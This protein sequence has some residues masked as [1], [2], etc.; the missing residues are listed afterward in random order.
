MME[1]ADASVLL[2]G[3]SARV[4]PVGA[5]LDARGFD[6]GFAS[7]LSEVLERL[8]SPTMRPSLV[9]LDIRDASPWQADSMERMAALAGAASIPTVR[10]GGPAF[11]RLGSEPGQV[12]L[13]DEASTDE[14]VGAACALHVGRGP[15]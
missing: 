11:A 4:G 5:G 10:V 8:S 12:V 9:I 1:R 15:G 3:D 14:I 7:T 2:I 6:L 13:S